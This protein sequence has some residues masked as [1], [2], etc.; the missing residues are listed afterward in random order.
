MYNTAWKLNE[1]SFFHGNLKPSN[2]FYK[3]GGWQIGEC[4]LPS[5]RINKYYAKGF[6]GIF[7]KN[8]SVQY[9]LASEQYGL[10]RDL[11]ALGIMA[12]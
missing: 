5:A 10:E 9:S 6:E 1:Q 11:Y 8:K 4:G 12:I 7:D 2:I 3:D